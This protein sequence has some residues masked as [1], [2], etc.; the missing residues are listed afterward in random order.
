MSA[1][2]R[3]HALLH[4]S[5]VILLLTIL[6]AVPL[7]TAAQDDVHVF[8]TGPDTLPTNTTVQY[9]IR[10]TG[11]PADEDDAN[12][13]FSYTGRLDMPNPIGAIMDPQEGI[14]MENIFIVNVTTPETPQEMT[15][16]VNGTS[17]TNVNDTMWSGDVSKAIEVFKPYRVNISAVVRNPGPADVKGALVTFYVDG[18]LIVNKTVDLA[19]NTTQNVNWDWVA[20]PEEKGEHD[21]EVRINEAGTLLEFDTGDNVMTMTIYVGEKPERPVHPIMFFSNGGLMFTLIFFASLFAFAAF[22]MWW[23]TRRGRAYYTPT[24]SSVMYFEGFLM[25]AFS[26]PMF[27]V[28]DVLFA[29]TEATGDPWVTSIAATAL[30]A[31]GF[32]TVLFTWRRSRK[33]KR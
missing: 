5:L 28:A 22:V 7:N 13:S 24:Q 9:T 8:I 16:V 10:I 2:R 21:V 12:G 3:G 23:R 19:A 31:L 33:K 4:I 15:M 32:L 14:S 17:F 20:P 1:H 26:L 6:L 29:N 27:Y 30:F 11:G 25:V 18:D